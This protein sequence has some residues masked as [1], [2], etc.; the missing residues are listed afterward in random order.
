MYFN[1]SIPNIFRT[2]DKYQKYFSYYEQ[3]SKKNIEKE[4]SYYNY[5]ETSYYN[6]DLFNFELDCRLIGRDHAGFYIGIN[7]LC[8]HFS[9]RTYDFRHW[10]YSN[11]RWEG[12]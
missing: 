8:W 2:Y 9:F 6:Y 3:I 5:E 1:V 11:W 7:I 4:T 10:D 12:K